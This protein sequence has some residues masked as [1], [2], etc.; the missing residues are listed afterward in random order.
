MNMNITYD[1]FP[2]ALREPKSGI[3]PEKK[4]VDKFLEQKRE[5]IFKVSCCLSF[6]PHRGLQ[7]IINFEKVAKQLNNCCRTYR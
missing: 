7:C 6:L 3:S 4:F 2:K 5:K 1:L